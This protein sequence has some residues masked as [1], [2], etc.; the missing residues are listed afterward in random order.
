MNAMTGT[1]G[2]IGHL[3]AQGDRKEQHKYRHRR[4]DHRVNADVHDLQAQGARAHLHARTHV[5]KPNPKAREDTAL[6]AVIVQT[7][8][9]QYI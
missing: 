5:C 4:P 2:M 7:P 1:Y 8:V 3:Q 9:Q 6:K